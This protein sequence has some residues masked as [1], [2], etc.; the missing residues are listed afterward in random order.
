MNV[1]DA[2]ESTPSPVVTATTTT[3]PSRMQRE[4]EILRESEE[5]Q[6]K[7]RQ[8]SRQFHLAKTFEKRQKVEKKLRRVLDRLSMLEVMMKELEKNAA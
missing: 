6:R 3:T 2:N 8:F 5:L 1:E 7:R 4:H